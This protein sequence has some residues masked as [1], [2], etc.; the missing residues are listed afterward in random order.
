MTPKAHSAYLCQVVLSFS[1]SRPHHEAGGTGQLRSVGMVA[2]TDLLR[3]LT[4][5][6]DRAAGRS[7]PAASAVGEDDVHPALGQPVVEPDAAAAVVSP[8]LNLRRF[9]SVVIRSGASSHGSLLL[10]SQAGGFGQAVEEGRL[11]DLVDQLRHLAV[12]VVL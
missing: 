9:A 2:M 1:D 6:Y 5:R 10:Q 4:Y 12:L 7:R 11:G 8:W 3:D